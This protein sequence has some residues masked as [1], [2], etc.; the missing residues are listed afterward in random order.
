ML[1]VLALGFASLAAAGVP[2][3]RPGSSLGVAPEPYPLLHTGGFTGRP[4][5]LSP[6]PLAAYQWSSAL[7]DTDSL[8][9]YTL[10][11]LTASVL[12]GKCADE[13]ASLAT[14]GKGAAATVTITPT[15]P[16]A[17]RLDFGVELPAWFEID[18]L[19]NLTAAA[20]AAA[21][22]KLTMAIGETDQPWQDTGSSQ[23]TGDLAWKA[24]TPVAYETNATSVAARTT[25]RLE[26]NAQLYEGVRFAFV[27][28]TSSSPFTFTI[29][30]ARVVVQTK[31]VNYTGHFSA[32][33]DDLLT[34]VWWTAAW[35]V[36]A[37]FQKTFFG[38]ILIDRG[39][40]ESWTGDA[41]P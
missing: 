10:S 29:D 21:N 13:C 36:R 16:L 22:V 3:P 27:Y 26:T 23:V 35:T 30:A 33:Q 15:A 40:R 7:A 4:A 5:P 38:S 32:P 11:P 28:A 39:D 12:S 31:P 17:L 24:G 14:P 8:Q 18:S 20:A 41:H 9:A 25:Y 37:A 19:L 6:D 34:K 1:L 2:A